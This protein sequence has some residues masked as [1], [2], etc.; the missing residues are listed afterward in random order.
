MG[1]KAGLVR[2][3]EFLW[4]KVVAKAGLG[5]MAKMVPATAIVLALADIQD[6]GDQ[7]M[8]EEFLDGR[9]Y[10]PESQ[11]RPVL[12][13]EPSLLDF[14]E[15]IREIG[16]QSLSGTIAKGMEL[17]QHAEVQAQ[18]FATS[19]EQHATMLKESAE[20]QA[21]FFSASAEQH[22]TTLKDVSKRSCD[23]FSLW[24]NGILQRARSLSVATIP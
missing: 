4:A 9:R 21:H 20:V 10:L 19:A 15:L 7:G 11:Y 12:D 8:I 16:A 17:A 14:I 1:A 18:A 24:T 6:R 22:A 5:S 2:A 13:A 23:D 3:T